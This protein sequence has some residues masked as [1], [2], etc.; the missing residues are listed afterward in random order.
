MGLRFTRRV[1]LFPGV[2]VNLSKSGASMSFG[3]RGAHYTVGSRGR[4]VTVGIPGT[5]LYYTQ[6]DRQRPTGARAGRGPAAAP[7]VP[8]VQPADRLR[9]GFFKRLVTPPEERRFVDGLRAIT[10]G[11]EDQAFADFSAASHLADGAMFAGALALKRGLVGQAEQLIRSA[12]AH[13]DQLGASLRQYGVSS[14]L[15]LQ[16]TDELTA[17]LPH[18]RDGAL[19]VLVEIL[20]RAG[21]RDEALRTLDLIRAGSPDDP[22]VLA[23]TCELLLDGGADGD[24]QRVIALTEKVQNLTPVQTVLLLFRARAL[25]QLK[26]P[27]AA[28]QVATAALARRAGRSD[29]LLHEL[30]YERALAYGELGNAKRSRAD[31]ERLYAEDSTFADVAQR[32]GVGAA[33]A[34]SA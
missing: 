30:R 23:S 15:S 3:V 9:V 14:L 8:L 22:V 16:I 27:E 2:S 12:V 31:L 20:Q 7:A 29:E 1:R 26:L 18:T 5:G 32:L 11:Q 21:R 10:Q 13:A 4:R 19:L 25:R 6:T 24:R 33:A 17:Q 34:S 28:V